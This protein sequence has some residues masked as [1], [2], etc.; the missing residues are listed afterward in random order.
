MTYCNHK[1]PD[2]LYASPDTL[3]ALE[4][5]AYEHSIET[6]SLQVLACLLFAFRPPAC[7]SI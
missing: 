1:L 6:G 2:T 5:S 7:Q 4:H 3:N